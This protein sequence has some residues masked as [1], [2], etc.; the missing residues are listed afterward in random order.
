[1][2]R[3][4]SLEGVVG[5][6]KKEYENFVI[7]IIQDNLQLKMS[8]YFPM[9]CINYVLRKKIATAA[10]GGRFQGACHSWQFASTISRAIASHHADEGEQF[11]YLM[12]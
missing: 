5:L 9:G 3:L 12:H 7:I 10:M 8:K 11:K 4:S 6:G 1:M 2:M